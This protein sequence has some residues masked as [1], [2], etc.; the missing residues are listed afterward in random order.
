MM[1]NTLT[2]PGVKALVMV[3]LSPK[4]AVHAAFMESGLTF[5]ELAERSG[6]KAGN[7]ALLLSGKA[8]S[9]LHEYRDTLAGV[10]G[11]DRAWVD[12]NLPRR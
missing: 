8:S 5:R 4:V 12:D 1:E 7:F 9:E 10:L 2:G 11:V 6:L 3:G